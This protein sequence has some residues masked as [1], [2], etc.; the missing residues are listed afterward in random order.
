MSSRTY[1][2]KAGNFFD[3][4]FSRAMSLGD[5]P[6][7]RWFDRKECISTHLSPKY[8]AALLFGTCQ[9]KNESDG[10]D[11]L[12]NGLLSEGLDDGSSREIPSN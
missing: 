2:I 4:T 10:D 6:A 8:N 11:G 7:A 3:I 1:S 12:L 5:L 9:R